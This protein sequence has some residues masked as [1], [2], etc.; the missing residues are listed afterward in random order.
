MIWRAMFGNGVPIGMVKIT[1]VPRP[2]V[3]HKDRGRAVPVFCG[4]VLGATVLSACVQLAATSSLQ[5]MPAATSV[6]VVC[7]DFRTV[8]PLTFFR[9]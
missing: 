3:I 8:G 7:Q 2:H 1:I 9:A 4:A 6:F 5:R